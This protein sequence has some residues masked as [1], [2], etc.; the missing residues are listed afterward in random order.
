MEQSTYTLTI[1]VTDSQLGR[2]RADVKRAAFDI[3]N[4]TLSNFLTADL[5]PLNL[6]V[7][8]VVR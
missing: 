6:T 5:T 2:A 4:D 8:E 3:L 1:T 7:A